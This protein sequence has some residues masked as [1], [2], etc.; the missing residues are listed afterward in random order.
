SFSILLRYS[1]PLA[2][3]PFQSTCTSSIV[4]SSL[5]GRNT[6][7]RAIASFHSLT[8]SSFFLFTF[9]LGG[10]FFGLLAGRG[11]RGGV[12]SL[13]PFLGF[14]LST[15]VGSALGGTAVGERTGVQGEP[16]RFCLT[17]SFSS[18]LSLLAIVS[19]TRSVLGTWV[20]ASSS[21]GVPDVLRESSRESLL[22]P[23][24][25]SS[26]LLLSS[27]LSL[28]RCSSPFLF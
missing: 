22:P 7:P 20:G 1:R 10:G 28:S 19:A 23:P 18:I 13:L 26:P 21:L 12:V 3:H 2:P 16:S 15:C 6:L 25:P 27:S 4:S 17:D 14:S 24:P 8:S 11:G 5:R 9:F